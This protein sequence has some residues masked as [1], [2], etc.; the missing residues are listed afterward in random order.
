MD[1][2]MKL[3]KKYKPSK[4]A[5]K[6]IKEYRRKLNSGELDCEKNIKEYLYNCFK[7]NN[8]SEEIVKEVISISVGFKD[9]SFEDWIIKPPLSQRI[10]NVAGEIKEVIIG[11]AIGVVG[12]LS[13]V[14]FIVLVILGVVL[15]IDKILGTALFM[16][17]IV[18]IIG[19]VVVLI[20]L[21]IWWRLKGIWWRLWPGSQQDQEE[22]VDWDD[23]R[24]S[25]EEGADRVAAR[26]NQA[27]QD[28]T[29]KHF[30]ENK[31]KVI[32]KCEECGHD[33][34]HVVDFY[35]IKQRVREY[36]RCR[37]GDSGDGIAATKTYIR[38][39]PMGI[40]SILTDEHRLGEKVDEKKHA[41]SRVLE[42]ELEV[43]C[44]GCYVSALRWITEETTPD[45]T[46]E[47]HED[48]YVLCSQCGHNIE[49]GRSHED[50]GRIWSCE[51]NDFNPKKCFPDERYKE[52]WR[53][54][55]WIRGS[56]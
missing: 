55:G 27:V 21:K 19:Y 18:A 17:V 15:L 5:E 23:G 31:D 52:N 44:D 53:N 46:E 43:S 3:S 8:I 48:T 28:N 38:E 49:F 22:T 33:I 34:F 1:G 9:S 6:I 7:N 13:G 4:E 25:A 47:L 10:R 39:T 11:V 30:D 54:R 29:Y 26:H 45:D 41:I 14:V 2:T 32:F 40:K 56:R 50:G 12:I 36:I 42:Q 37:C 35:M 51:C 16:L 24:L 20:L